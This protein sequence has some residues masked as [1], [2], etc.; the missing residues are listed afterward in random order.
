MNTKLL[1]F[2][3]LALSLSLSQTSVAFAEHT[4]K[5]FDGQRLEKAIK[6]LDL[7]ADQKTKIE[8]ICEKAKADIIAQ[9]ETF[10]AAHMEVNEAFKSNSM[11]EDKMDS[12]VSKE[13]K[14]VGAM[15]KIRM[16]ERLDI[17]NVLTDDQKAK[18]ADMM[19]K[20]E[21]DHEGHAGD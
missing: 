21:N 2:S 1:S 9:R 18:V 10:R 20:W 3:A 11:T 6:K 5:C 7:S 13:E 15:I 16:M 14:I 4:V 12:F 19:I 17:N 8:A